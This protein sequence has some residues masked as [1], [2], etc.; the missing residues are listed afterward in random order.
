MLIINNSGCL[1][2]TEFDGTINAE[3]NESDN[4]ED[5]D[6]DVKYFAHGLWIWPISHRWFAI[7]ILASSL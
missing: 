1:R 7:F 3:E 6:Y 5:I 4:G 2:P